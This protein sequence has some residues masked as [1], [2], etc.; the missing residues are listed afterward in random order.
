ML[1]A[2][3]ILELKSRLKASEI[4]FSNMTAVYVANGE[5][6]SIG[7]KKFLSLEDEEFYKYLDIAKGVLD[8]KIDERTLL[9]DMK[10]NTDASRI[11]N[12][13][14]SSR[15]ID[16]EVVI[17]MTGRI[18][19]KL[20]QIGNFLVVWFA[21]IYDIPKIGTDGIDQD[22]SEDVY[23]YIVCAICPVTLSK[24]CLG[25][26]KEERAICVKNR[27]WMVQKP[28]AGFIYPAFEERAVE[29][30]KI[31]FYTSN[32]KEP[33]HKLMEKGLETE[34]RKTTTEICIR[35]EQLYQRATESKEQ[36]DECITEVNRQ[37]N[38]LLKERCEEY[39][40]TKEDLETAMEKAELPD[41]IIQKIVRWYDDEFDPRPMLKWLIS[42][43]RIKEAEEQDKKEKL[44][45]I[46][47]AAVVEIENK[48]EEETELTQKMKEMI[49][50]C[51]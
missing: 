34:K 21:D 8:K 7:N 16:Q 33:P 3:D 13:I 43:N 4:T 12:G 31:I 36:M 23:Q 32:P 44:V 47:K 48:T 40:L 20:D 11:L 17:E 14:N 41:Y 18:I 46:L 42:P 38:D 27:E 9:L 51:R 39:C 37:L 10:K 26:D 25:Y 30:E 2:N 49:S 45:K 6:A 19:E 28:C 24:S 29:D 35:Y 50:Q 1:R 5:V 22:E 15:L